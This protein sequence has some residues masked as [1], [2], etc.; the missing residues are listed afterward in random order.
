MLRHSL[1]FLGHNLTLRAWYGESYPFVDNP[2]SLA[3]PSR[4]VPRPPGPEAAQA[5]EELKRRHHDPTRPLSAWKRLELSR[6]E[7][8]IEEANTTHDGAVN[9]WH[10]KLCGAGP[11]WWPAQE[12]VVRDSENVRGA[13]MEIFPV[14]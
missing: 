3:L 9:A 8:E 11:E 7:A 1:D 2:F 5:L 6:K 4:T 13:L 14:D 10:S 12:P